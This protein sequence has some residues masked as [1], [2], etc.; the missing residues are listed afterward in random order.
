MYLILSQKE[1]EA[2]YSPQKVISG[3]FY[4]CF[5]KCIKLIPVNLKHLLSTCRKKEKT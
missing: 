2:A 3:F 4:G 1:K 5:R